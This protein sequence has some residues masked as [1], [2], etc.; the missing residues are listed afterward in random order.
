MNMID[1]ALKFVGTPYIWAG[2]GPYFDCSGF[3]KEVLQ[4]YGHL[5]YGDWTAEQL[6]TILSENGWVSVNEPQAGDIVCFGISK[7]T[8]IALMVN[9]WQYVEAGGGNS[10]CTTVANTT[11]MVRL[12]PLTWREPDLILRRK[13]D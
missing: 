5:P 13:H 7:V 10:K 4:A 8:H 9:G 12:R 6:T 3:I 2:N 1:Y 11:G